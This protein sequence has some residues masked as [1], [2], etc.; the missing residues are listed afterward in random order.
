MKK[1]LVILFYPKTEKENVSKNIPLALLKLGSELKGAGFDV[2]VIDE[3]FEE[4]YKDYLKDILN[5]AIFFGVSAMTGYQ[6][7]GGLKAS[8]FVKKI[9]R[10]LTVVW[11]GWHPSI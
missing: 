11:G 4:N 1:N 10:N 7:Y 9:N 2:A 3:R 8:S 6:I 5:K